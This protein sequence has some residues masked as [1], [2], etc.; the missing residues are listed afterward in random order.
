MR[1]PINWARIRGATVRGIFDTRKGAAQKFP[2]RLGVIPTTGKIV[3]IGIKPASEAA[4][5]GGR[6]R[7]KQ[8]CIFWILKI[9]LGKESKIFVRSHPEIVRSAEGGHLAFHTK[10]NF[11]RLRR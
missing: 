9:G 6:G 11:L 10:K 2:R 1:P 8:V 4:C 3:L 7:Q 5:S